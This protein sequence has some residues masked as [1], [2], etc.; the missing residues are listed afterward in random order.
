MPSN[1]PGVRIERT[2]L[3]GKTLA[4]GTPILDPDL[5]AGVALRFAPRPEVTDPAIPVPIPPGSEYL[6]AIGGQFVIEAPVDA[7]VGGTLSVDAAGVVTATAPDAVGPN[8]LGTI[9][10]IEEGTVPQRCWFLYQRRSA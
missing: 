4:C 7:Q 5:G 3:T 6:H 2:N 8:V 9:T 10:Y 1:A